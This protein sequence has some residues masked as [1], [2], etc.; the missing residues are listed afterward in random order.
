M[1]IGAENYSK[2][3]WRKTRQITERTIG[4]ISVKNTKQIRVKNK[5][6]HYGGKQQGT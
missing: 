2:S 4:R 6:A 3:G 5:G 1:Q